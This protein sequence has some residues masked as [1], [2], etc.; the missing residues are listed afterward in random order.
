MRK[1]NL[2]VI[3]C[4]A[5][6]TNQ[7]IGANQIKKWHTDP[8]PKGRG[9]KDIGYH[10]VIRRDGSLEDGRPNQ[11]IGAHAKGFNKTS[12]GICM[13]GGLNLES[14]PSNNF[15]K[16][17]YKTLRMLIRFLQKLYN[18][19]D[20]RVIGHRELPKVHKSCPCFEVSPWLKKNKMSVS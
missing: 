6:R 16:A 9:W 4:S 15:S 7:D 10:Y 20:I 8:K 19:P 5:T 3:H 13:V 18:I 12:L 2:L 14:K 11:I 17:Q 1:I